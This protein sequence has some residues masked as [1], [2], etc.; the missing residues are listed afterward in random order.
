MSRSDRIIGDRCYP[1]DTSTQRS[2]VLAASPSSID[3]TG[4][5]H[6]AFLESPR[7]PGDFERRSRVQDH[8][9]ASRSPLAI[10]DRTR[11]TRR[12]GDIP[13]LQIFR[14][15]ATEA[16]LGRVKVSLPDGSVLDVVHRRDPGGRELVQTVL[17]AEQFCSDLPPREDLG[18]EGQHPLIGHPHDLR[19]WPG[20]VR[21]WP[22]K[23]EDRRDPQ[24]PSDRRR[25]AH[26]RMKHRSEHEGDTGVGQAALHARR[27]QIDPHAE[28]L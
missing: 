7:K 3:R 12:F 22:Q 27:V 24:L 20:R 16:E 19:V 23:V 2:S 5:R 18:H 11:D 25:M 6:H 9:V 26:R 4:C 10:D 17:A 1:F 15:R 28:C 13:S 8:D 14:P 21:E